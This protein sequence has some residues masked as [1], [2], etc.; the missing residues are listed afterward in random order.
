M[1]YKGLQPV[2][3][4]CLIC[5]F[6][7]LSLSINSEALEGQPIDA[8]RSPIDEIIHILRDPQYQGASQRAI[9]RQ[10]IWTI[11]ND[12]FDFKEISRRTLARFWNDLTPE[13][14]KEFV[15][16]FAAFLSNIYLKRIQNTY[17]NE[18]VEFIEQD[19]L[20]DT[21][22]SVKTKV[23]RDGGIEIPVDYSL[24]KKGTG[25]KVY[26]VAIEGVSLVKNY[27][28]QFKAILLKQDPSRLIETLKKKN[29]AHNNQISN[30][31]GNCLDLQRVA[32]RC[33]MAVW[34]N[35]DLAESHHK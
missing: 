22:A 15:E 21:K 13:Q 29:E 4:P 34:F 23:I 27:R 6:I 11:A 7:F 16:T 14:Q 25:W 30:A 20:S 8:I 1:R 18:T 32:R 12:F 24:I 2:I 17:K 31:A 26:D 28:T 3:K 9:Q 33:L 5:F 19:L 35:R 10:K